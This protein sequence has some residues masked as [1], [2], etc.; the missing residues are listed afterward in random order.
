M[1]T[2]LWNSSRT[3]LYLCQENV[4]ILFDNF[5]TPKNATNNT[6]SNTS[7][8][9]NYPNITNFTSPLMNFTSPLMNFTSP[10][11][12]FTSPSS[13]LSS[14][15]SS[16][17]SPSSSLSSP[18]SSLSS[19]LTKINEVVTNVNFVIN[20]T[21]NTTNNTTPNLRGHVPGPN[22]H[23]LHL[24]WLLL[25]LI[26]V[27]TLFIYKRKQKRATIC[28]SPSE[29]YTSEN[30]SD[31]ASISLAVVAK[32]AKPH[33]LNTSGISS[34]TEETSSRSPHPP[35]PVR[36]PPDDQKNLPTLPPNED[37]N[38]TTERR[39]PTKVIKRGNSMI[40]YRGKKKGDVPQ[41][42]KSLPTKHDN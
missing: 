9:I 26:L 19:T 25:P 17:S 11:M 5:T 3:F 40:V 12:N 36:K 38:N 28:P 30:A 6:V 20:S 10:L 31:K 15:S 18:S 22:L 42:S 33:N 16:L 41:R 14:P 27:L 4:Q 32:I 8:I 34:S 7:Q 37:V 21:N 35:L 29:K 23:L 13:S 1:C 39:Q 2:I 24:L